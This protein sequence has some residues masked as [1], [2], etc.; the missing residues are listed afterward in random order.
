MLPDHPHT[1]PHS[2]SLCFPFAGFAL[3]FLICS[4]GSNRFVR[5]LHH[6]HI[7]YISHFSPF[8]SLPFLLLFFFST[9]PTYP[10]ST[11]N[12]PKPF[13]AI[14]FDSTFIRPEFPQPSAFSIRYQ[15]I[16]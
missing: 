4:R 12:R 11:F 1:P 9:S 16:T 14:A 5:S 15:I 10:F 8:P 3:L 13:R 2:R 7:R 6:L